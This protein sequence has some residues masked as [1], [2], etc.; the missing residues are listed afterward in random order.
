MVRN[1]FVAPLLLVLGL[2][3]CTTSLVEQPDLSPEVAITSATTSSSASYTLTATATDDV[4]VTALDYTLNGGPSQPIAPVVS[5]LSV[6]LT[7]DVGANTITVVARDAAGNQGSDQITVTY[8]PNRAPN[9]NPSPAPGPEETGRLALDIVGLPVNLPANVRVMN[10]DGFS[11]LVTRSDLLT[12][13]EPGSYTVVAAPVPDGSDRYLP[14]HSDQL[15]TVEAGET[16]STSVIYLKE[17]ANTGDL[18]LFITGLAAGVEV[19]VTVRRV[20]GGR[21]VEVG[22][23]TTLYNL[24]AGDYLVTAAEVAPDSATFSPDAASRTVEIRANET[25]Q[26]NIAYT[27]TRLDPP[28]FGLEGALRDA[29]HA[30]SGDIT[31]ADVGMLTDLFARGY[32]ISDP[33]LEG[34]QYAVNLEDLHLNDNDLA[35]LSGDAFSALVKLKELNLENNRLTTLPDGLFTS[36]T[37]LTSLYLGD[38]QLVSLQDGVF[39]GLTQVHELFLGN[40]QLVSLPNGAFSGLDS[41]DYLLL[42]DNQLASLP[43]GV[44]S[45]LIDLAFLDLQDNHLNALDVEW[46]E[47]LTGLE[48]VYIDDNCL[49]PDKVPFAGIIEEI[50]RLGSGPTVHSGD[51]RTD[52]AC[53]PVPAAVSTFDSDDEGW[54]VAAEEPT[55]NAGGYITANDSMGSPFWEAPGLYHGDAEDYYGRQLSFRL[56]QSTTGSFVINDV[57]L[58]GSGKTIYYTLPTMPTPGLDA[59]RHRPGTGAGWVDVNHNP[60]TDPEDIKEVL[61]GLNTLL[62]RWDYGSGGEGDLDGVRIRCRLRGQLERSPWGLQ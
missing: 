60:I 50:E 61:R 7:L 16:A 6:G 13:L 2:S 9:P 62:I 34:L 56:R 8:D 24:P 40:N 10:P 39:S 35:E 41:V 36:L 55:W 46:F 42:N 28:D 52:I 32:G 57:L 20:G 12:D 26:T 19:E 25:T 48:A 11:M 59:L 58:S 44:F 22:S 4:G 43:V 21:D 1:R 23:S 29:L 45:G 53:P 14:S 27:C 51:P 54:V 5:P 49:H 3:A 33:E 31:C 17:E 15:V 38:N 30:P 47:G 37:N 18:S